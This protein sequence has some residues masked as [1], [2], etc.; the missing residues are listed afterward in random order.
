MKTYVHGV[1]KK[2]TDRISQ[3]T[4]IHRSRC[5]WTNLQ[6]SWNQ[7]SQPRPQFFNSCFQATSSINQVHFTL[8]ISGFC[9]S[10]PD[11]ITI[12]L[13]QLLC[14]IFY[15][16]QVQSMPLTEF[17]SNWICQSCYMDFSKVLDGFVK[18]DIWISLSCT[19]VQLLYDFVKVAKW[20]C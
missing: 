12:K 17:C 14:V 6:P 2:V 8:H 13:A 4:F 10:Y 16:I 15:Q 1:P 19:I 18:I 5:L 7:K 9:I 11:N 3:M 20:I